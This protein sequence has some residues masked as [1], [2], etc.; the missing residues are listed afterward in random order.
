MVSA[1]DFTLKQLYIQFILIGNSP[2]EDDKAGH[3]SFPRRERERE[4][5]TKKDNGQ[6]QRCDAQGGGDQPRGDPLREPTSRGS[7]LATRRH[8]THAQSV[9]PSKL[10]T[11]DVHIQKRRQ[12]L[13]ETV[14]PVQYPQDV[15][16]KFCKLEPALIPPPSLPSIH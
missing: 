11:H 12:V 7:K 8:Q 4:T 14:C 3:I 16:S 10:P 2:P 6:R 1:Y 13:A 15:H 5:H 9:P